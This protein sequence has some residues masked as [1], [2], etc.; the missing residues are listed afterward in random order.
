MGQ[1]SPEQS[2]LSAPLVALRVAMRVKKV[3]L[4]FHLS[5]VSLL[6]GTVSFLLDF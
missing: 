3:I 6:G 4:N 2:L 1:K 5:E